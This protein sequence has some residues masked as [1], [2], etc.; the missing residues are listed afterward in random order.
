MCLTVIPKFSSPIMPNSQM[1]MAST[2]A[3]IA[4]K[5][6]KFDMIP[7]TA[8]TVFDAPIE[9]ASKAFLASLH[10]K[11]LTDSNYSKVD[12]NLPFGQVFNRVP[13]SLSFL[14]LRTDSLGDS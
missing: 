1:N 6:I 2:N 13:V 11:L 12:S 14:C 7:A 8:P 4:V 3:N 5:A 9:M 10:N